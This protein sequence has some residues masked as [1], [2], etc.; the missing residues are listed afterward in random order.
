MILKRVFL[1]MFFS[2]VMTLSV[3]CGGN[4]SEGVADGEDEP[5]VELTEE[6]IAGEEA[7]HQGSQQ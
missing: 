6:E 1:L 3:G 5:E 4:V 7:S 2:L